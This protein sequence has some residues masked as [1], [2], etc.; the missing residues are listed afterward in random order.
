[1][2]R[3]SSNK[4]QGGHIMD[5]GGIANGYGNSNLSTQTTDIQQ[6]NSTQDNET[7]TSAQSS[8]DPVLTNDFV[9]SDGS[10]YADAA[11]GLTALK[12]AAINS[13]DF[14][15]V[16]V[17][18]GAEMSLLGQTI[19]FGAGGSITID[20]YGD[21][22][23]SL[24]AGGS[25]NPS[26]SN[27]N[28]SDPVSGQVVASAGA[29]IG[30]YQG[31]D[32]SQEM[33]KNFIAGPSVETQIMDGIGGSKIESTTDSSQYAYTVDFGAGIGLRSGAS[34]SQGGSMTGGYTILL[35]PNDTPTNNIIDAIEAIPDI[36]KNNYGSGTT[37]FTND[38][39][40]LQMNIKA[41]PI[42]NDNVNATVNTLGYLE[43]G[44]LQVD[45]SS[46]VYI[47][48]NATINVDSTSGI[49]VT[50]GASL[51]IDSGSTL[52]LS[53]GSTI[54][55]ADNSNLDLSD[56]IVNI[57][58]GNIDVLNGTVNN[59]GTLNMDGSASGYAYFENDGT[60]NNSGTISMNGSASGDVYFD[61]YGGTVSNS[62]TINMDGSSSGDAFFNNDGGTVTN[63]ATINMDGS[64]SGDAFFN[65]NG[66][67]VTNS[68]TINMDGSSSGDAFFNNDE[69]TVSNSATINMDG[70]I[71]G[72]HSLIMKEM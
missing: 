16:G 35:A 68:A 71:R 59:S 48:P 33:L 36:I 55:V 15:T 2:K 38:D 43:D 42:L 53:N 50:D 51:N 58:S 8:D 20:K 49:T 72:M 34:S 37:T 21:I 3:I 67:T 9:L 32:D 12:D 27:T 47:D 4:K 14:V 60:M 31:S 30:F 54:N 57:N 6:A 41:S 25:L 18:A 65:N 1:M 61:N 17:Q 22:Y 11:Q 10:M 52:E 26:T 63:S 66:G 5:V 56:G 23:G 46:N 64:S 45:S 44:S 69:G 62:A 13:V 7:N 19:G 40:L 70:S 39:Q 24:G 29:E 28:I